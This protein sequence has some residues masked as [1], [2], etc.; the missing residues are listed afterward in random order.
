MI[1]VYEL[2]SKG[3]LEDYLGNNDKMTN[4]TWIQRL[5]ICLDI[6]HGLNYIHTNTDQDKQKIIHRDIKS[7]NILLGENW[8]AKI[9]DFGLSKL[10]PADQDASTFDASTIAGTPMYFDPEYQNSGK[11]NKK[12]DIYSFGVV[13]FEILTGRLAYDFD[14]GIAPIARHHFE[15]GTLMEIVDRKIKEET[16]EH[17]FSLSKG[18][19]KES[20]EIFSE[21]AFR[22]LAETQVQR[23]T[24]DVVINEL[25]RALKCQE[26]HKDNLKLSLEDIKLATQSFS[27]DNLIGHGDLWNVYKGN[28]H[29]HNIIAAKRLDRKSAEGEA[30]FMTE[31]EILMEYKHENVI[32]LVGYIDEEDEKIIVY[33]YASRGSLDKYL[34]DDSLTWVMRLKICLDIAIGLE[35]LH[36]STSSPEMVI[37][38]DI[39][40]SNILLFDDWKAKIT[41]F[42]LSLVCPTNEDVG[43]VD[44]YSSFSESFYV[45]FNM[46]NAFKGE[47]I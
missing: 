2:A 23:P 36:G 3:S 10:H 37:H 42:G 28:T 30:E 32:G 19:D 43:F 34:S 44:D 5:K 13:L 4:I 33:D 21:I 12:S 8:E 26:N 16:D 41:D 7:A 27:Q 1:L 47:F 35:Y 11:L 29:G 14:N 25:K 22:C 24:I 39:S 40:S 20:L 31:L 46:F 6:A 18:P 38:R 9:A 45:V 15:K 17:V